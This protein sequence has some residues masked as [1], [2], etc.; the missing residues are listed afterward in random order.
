VTH[1]A[2]HDEPSTTG[3]EMNFE[4][5]E[6]RMI[7]EHRELTTRVNKLNGFFNTHVFIALDEAEQV[8]MRAQQVFMRGYQDMLDERIGVMLAKKAG[9]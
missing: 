8:R 7:D 3:T 2:W 1:H 6:Q 5:H 9:R 4:P